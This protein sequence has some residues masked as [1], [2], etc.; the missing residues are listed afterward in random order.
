MA[1]VLF[2]NPLIREEDDPRHVPYGRRCWRPSRCA[3]AIRSRSTTP[4]PGGPPTSIVAQIL[5]ADRWDVIAHGRDHHRVPVDQAHRAAW[6]RSWRR[7]RWSVAGGGFLTSMPRDIMRLLPAGGRRGRRRGASS[8][9]PSSCSGWMPATATGRRCTGW[10][11]AMPPAASWSTP[12]P[13][14]HGA[15]RSCR[16]RPG[17]SSRSRGLLQEQHGPF[18]RG[19]D[20]GAA[21]A[22]HQRLLRLLADLPLLLPPRHRR[23]PPDGRA[24]TASATSSSRTSAT[25][26]T[27]ARATWWTS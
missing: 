14:P 12:S 1:K 24:A 6:P 20:A 16:I 8:R 2:V 19:G 22:R 25:S 23:R 10:P 5:T 26:A 7:R 18:L 4:T 21:A 3:T 13:A 27:T 11:G 9:S 15:R 17:S